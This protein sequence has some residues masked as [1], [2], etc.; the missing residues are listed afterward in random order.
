MYAVG[1]AVTILKCG[2]PPRQAR[3]SPDTFS[4]AAFTVIGTL[5]GSVAFARHTII[6]S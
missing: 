5:I 4:M 2:C 6:E 1:F 3:G